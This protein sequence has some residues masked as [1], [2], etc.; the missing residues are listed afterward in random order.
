[1]GG[2]SGVACWGWVVAAWRV[3]G[4]VGGGFA[5]CMCTEWLYNGAPTIRKFTVGG[6]LVTS[7]YTDLFK[8]LVVTLFSQ[9]MRQR[10]AGLAE[11]D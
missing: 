6:L 8:G 11:P 2:V 7:V 9:E 5:P 1:M 3:S 4:W 10:L